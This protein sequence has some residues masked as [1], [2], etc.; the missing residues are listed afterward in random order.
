MFQ[1][2]RFPTYPYFIQHTLPEVSSG[3]FPHSDTHGSRLICSSPW[4][5][6]AYRVL[7]RLLMPR[8]SPCALFRLTFVE[9]NF[10]H[11]V[12]VQ[13]FYRRPKT[14]Y[15]FVAS[16]L[17]IWPA[18]LGSNPVPVFYTST[19]YLS[20]PTSCRKIHLWFL[21]FFKNYAGS[22]QNLI[23]LLEIVSY[24]KIKMFPYCCLLIT[25]SFILCSVFKVHRPSAFRLP[26]SAWVFSQ[27]L[28]EI[29]SW[30]LQSTFQRRPYFIAL[31]H[32]FLNRQAVQ[33]YT[34]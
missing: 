14:S 10:A 20:I 15:R 18:S 5:F 1:F 4:L 27:R 28:I 32:C 16:P 30:R 34:L 11:S 6:A 26:V 9:A 17:R 21:F 19:Q 24:P 7:H 13:R 3:G 29:P 12:S 8:H 33:R 31:R 23:L 2:R 22:I 25:S